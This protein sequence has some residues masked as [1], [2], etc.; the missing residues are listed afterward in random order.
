M[1]Y[2][3]DGAG[4]RSVLSAVES[5]RAALPLDAQV[6]AFREEDLLSG[7][8]ADDCALLVMPGGA[9]LPFC[10][11]L[12]GAGNALIRGYVERGGSY[13]GLCAGAYYACRRV[14]F[15]IGTRLERQTLA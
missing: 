2:A 9:D 14:E 12:N 13:L 8:W 10:R 15:E 4:S 3:G 6:E 7:D 5:L 11:R 1:V